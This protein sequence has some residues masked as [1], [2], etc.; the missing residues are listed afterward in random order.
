MKE[1]DIERKLVKSVKAAGGLAMKFV[2]PGYAGVPDRLV[3]LPGGRIA[4]AET[5]AHGRIPR[6]LQLRRHGTLRILGF[7]VFVI[8]D[9]GQIEEMLHEIHA[10]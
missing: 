3:L 1:K 2:S 6:P 4:F 5:K 10:S 9:E 7:Q 8:D